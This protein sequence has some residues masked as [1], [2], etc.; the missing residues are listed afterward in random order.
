MG[1]G[2]V[3]GP[4]DCGVPVIVEEAD[5]AAAVAVIMGDVIFIGEC[6]NICGFIGEFIIL[7]W[8]WMSVGVGVLEFNRCSWCDINGL[9]SV[10]GNKD[11]ISVVNKGEE[12]NISCCGGGRFSCCC[13]GVCCFCFC[14]CLCCCCCCCNNDCGGCDD[15]GGAGG[16]TGCCSWGCFWSIF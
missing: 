2:I 5:A 16:G 14:F 6:I 9:L 1:I 11:K 7:D 13:N 12:D 10:L 15:D 4:I 3:P 8:P